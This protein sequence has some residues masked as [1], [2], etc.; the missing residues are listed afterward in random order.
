MSGIG[1]MRNCVETLGPQYI[2]K[3]IQNYFNGLETGNFP[4]LH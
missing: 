3:K 4:Y 2:R 1:K